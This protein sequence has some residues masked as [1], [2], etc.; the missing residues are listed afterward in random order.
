MQRTA[1]PN[2]NTG[3]YWD[4]I[5]SNREAYERET[6]LSR[7]K[8]TLKH[9]NKD[10]KFLDLSCG[11]GTLTEMVKDKYPDCEVYGMD[12][13]SK[14]IEDNKKRRSDIYYDTHFIGTI[15][16]THHHANTFDTIF[17][18]ETLEHLDCPEMVMADANI[19][20]KQG[21]KLIV[22][23]PLLGRIRSV[24]HVWDFSKEDVEKMYLDHG[25]K[26]V[27]FIE[28]EGNEGLLIIYAIGIKS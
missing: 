4:G 17:C 9:I 16:P 3:P 20:L 14:A 25:F 5:Y 6:G 28:L 22:S 8:E 18:G 1:N 13:S 27:Q 12:I 23:T 21:G 19:L 10:D 24:E 2:I 7:F 11:I 26:D 15:T